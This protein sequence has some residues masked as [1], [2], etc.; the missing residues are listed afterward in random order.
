[1]SFLYTVECDFGLEI[2]TKI[3]LLKEK[4]LLRDILK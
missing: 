2:K 4:I 3:D 1:V